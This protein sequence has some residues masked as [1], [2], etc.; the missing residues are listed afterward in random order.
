M[1]PFT[2]QTLTF[3]TLC[4][5]LAGGVLV[6][7][8]CKPKD[9][10]FS[11]I[12]NETNTFTGDL[13]CKSCHKDQY[14]DWLKSDHFK[15]MQK[16]D[17]STVLGNF[18]NTSFTADGITSIFFKRDGKF[19]INTQGDDG[20]NHDYAVK[21]TFGFYPL[22]QYLVEFPGGRMQAARVSWDSRQKK[23]FH[24]YAG[25]KIDYRDWLHWT[26]NA[27]NWNTMCAECHS[28][29]LKK[30][31]DIDADT[32]STTFDVI[33]VSCE[34]CHGP[35]KR[36]IDYANSEEYKK[37]S[38]VTNSFLLLK[39][40][41]EQLA[42]V[43]ACAPCHSVKS[44]ISAD[45]INSNELLDDYI[46][47]IPNTERFQADGQVN[48]EDYTYAS[49]L[50]SKMFHNNVKCSNC[51]NPHSEKLVLTGNQLC[52][53]CH[54]KTYDEPSHHFHAVNTTG[55]ECKNCHMPG[56]FYMGN[57]YRHDH[58]F[59]V[60]RPDLSVKY[61]TTNA[62]NNCHSDKTA[63]WAADAVVKWYGPKR[64]Y[65]FAE[66]LI[67]GSKQDAGSEVHLTRLL[68]D[69]AVP[70]IIK[71]TAA[72]YL[73]GI[74]TPSGLQALLTCLQSKNAQVRYEALRSLLNFPPAQYQNAAA[75]L[76]KDKV[77]A[78]RI[79]AADLF[80]DVPTEQIPQEYQ[81]A[82][83]TAKSELETYLRYQADFAHGNITIADHYMAANDLFTAE[84][85]YLRALR[86]DS[87]ANLA[88][89]SLSTLYS[90]QNKNQEAL[91][92]LQTAVKIDPKNPRIFYNMALLYNQLNKK[93]EAQNNFEK[94]FLYKSDNPRLYYNYGLFLQQKGDIKG[95]VSVLEKGLV[96]NREDADINYALAFVYMNNKQPDKAYPYALVLKRVAPANPEYQQLFSVLHLQ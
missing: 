86:K 57:D 81:E 83:V 87:L 76:L 33:N 73:G 7:E 23:W 14:N 17:D 69:P 31:Y 78:V 64:K 34:T 63:Q 11:A 39:K 85:F 68:N 67:P 10:D 53:Q 93:E 1:I 72:N 96:L 24:Q 2:K 35:G 77:R 56:K 58:S 32:Y 25:K 26:G 19:M 21:Y 51:H 38:R 3:L 20:K 9:Q 92:V 84:K 47:V 49:F 42:Q 75:T 62:C 52:L 28:T 12:H 16:P 6:M 8:H 61:A 13:A 44:N 43:N 59:R 88:R 60:P 94:A 54:S 40:G 95:A 65:H 89:L 37:G 45:K 66:D 79:A 90:K 27:E 4:I 50:Q 30:N 36:H 29:N 5:L 41:E 70:D 46:P 48:D 55:A 74:A 80:T 71:A 18:K 91:S 15:A 22:Q 82:Y